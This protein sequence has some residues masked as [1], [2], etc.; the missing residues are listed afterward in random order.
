MTNSANLQME[1]QRPVPEPEEKYVAPLFPPSYYVAHLVMVIYILVGVS[2]QIYQYTQHQTYRILSVATWPWVLS[3]SAWVLF[4][5]VVVY[6]ASLYIIARHVR[7][8]LADMEVTWYT[9]LPYGLFSFVWFGMFGR[10][11]IHYLSPEGIFID[12]LFIGK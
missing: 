10:L 2:L 8:K 5:S 1:N 6:G 3:G 11:F 9:L 4:L 7:S 12:N